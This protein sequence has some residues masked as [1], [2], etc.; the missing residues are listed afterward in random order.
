MRGRLWP[1][2]RRKRRRRS[3]A[4]GIASRARLRI[5]VTQGVTGVSRRV[6]QEMKKMG[7]LRAAKRQSGFRCQGHLC[8]E[9]AD[10]RT[11]KN[12][13]LVKKEGMLAGGL[14]GCK[15]LPRYL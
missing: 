2:R 9:R 12:H 14:W 6:T 5:H 13:E 15:N 8:R 3:A 1:K 7:R 11:S 10:L 4:V